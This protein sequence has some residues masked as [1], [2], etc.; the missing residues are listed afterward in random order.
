MHRPGLFSATIIAAFVL[1]CLV[2]QRAAV[3]TEMHK[4][5]KVLQ[6]EKENKCKALNGVSLS[7]VPSQGKHLGKGNK[8]DVRASGRERLL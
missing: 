8:K 1:F 6:K 5:A 2:L 7:V 4:L 3:N